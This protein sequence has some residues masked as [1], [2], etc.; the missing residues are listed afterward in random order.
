M[1]I[2]GRVCEFFLNFEANFP[3]VWL[4]GVGIIGCMVGSF[5][6]V[7]IYRLPLMLERRWQREAM[8]QLGQTVPAALI[9]FNLMLP[10]SCCPHCSQQLRI[11]DNVPLLSYLFLKGKAHCCGKRIPFHYPLVEMICIVLFVLTSWKFSPGLLLIGAWV[12][13]S[14][15][16]VLAFIDY[17]THLLPDTLTLPLLWLGLLFNL[18]DGYVSL[19]QA[20]MGAILGY[21]CLW[22]LYWLFRWIANKET[23]G[24]GDFKLLAALGAWMG[25]Q[26]I[27]QI[28]L[29]AA[30]S[31]LIVILLLRYLTQ[32]K[33]NINDPLAFGPWLVLGAGSYF[34]ISI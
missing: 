18:S 28:L 21:L 33:T 7:V 19:E 32:T 10:R 27:P 6:N 15:L 4:S 14:M 17:R 1:L 11:R 23:L 16:L 12:L 29:V 13:L 8:L 20:V 34:M 31:G 24:Y 25:W 5:L 30:G 26:A 9:P 2:N 22:S 3:L